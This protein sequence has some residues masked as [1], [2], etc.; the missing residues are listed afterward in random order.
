MS[1]YDPIKI[2]IG[3]TAAIEK[4]AELTG[5]D[6]AQWDVVKDGL[7]FETTEHGSVHVHLDLYTIISASSMGEVIIAAGLVPEPA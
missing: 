2:T 6:I 4:L 7:R 3:K 1:D 5:I